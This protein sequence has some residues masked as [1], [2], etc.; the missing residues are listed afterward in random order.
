MRAADWV[1]LAMACVLATV[2]AGAEAG[3]SGSASLEFGRF[4]TVAI[5]GATSNPSRVVLFVSGDGGWNQGVVDM[6]RELAKLDALVVGLD[7][8]RYLKQL[9][10][11]ETK[12]VYPAADF[13]ALS[14]FVQKKMGVPQYLHP[15][16][17][18]YSSGAT[19]VYATLVQSPPGTFR[20]AISLGFCPDLLL[21]K[22]MCPG[23][24]LTFHAGPK[25]KGV[26]FDPAKTLEDPWVALQGDIDKVCDPES[27]RAYVAKV[28]RGKLVW[29]P[30]VGHGYSVPSHWLPQLKDAYLEVVRPAAAPPLQA[31]APP[32]ADVPAGEAPGRSANEP[33]AA[34]PEAPG[35]ADLPLV[36]VP[37]KGES[38]NRFAVIVSGDGGWT[39]LD[40]HVGDVLAQAGIAV[41]GFDSLHYFWT[42]RTPDG[43]AADLA[44]ILRHYLAAWKKDHVVLVGYSRGADVL[45]FMVRRLPPELLEHVDLLALLGPSLTVGF[46]IHVSDFLGGK[47]RDD[48]PI[49]P[50]A[51]QLRVRKILCV[52]GESETETLCPSLPEPLSKPVKLKG[53][54]HFD[55]AYEEI[56]KLILDELPRP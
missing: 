48:L 36:E 1:A 51:T 5:Y 22:P 54:H 31:Q 32:A 10:S 23:S 14:Q 41:V 35:V 18:G 29:L 42:R 17:V 46:E 38:Q 37:A 26:L 15:V 11:A 12:C 27:T 24:G 39:S 4:G 47:H 21:R 52:Y 40:R 6:A 55:G 45:P 43:A 33:G 49:L 8:R 13:E 19:L 9:E 7:I 28:P 2:A 44:R 20:A 53:A 56:G 50:E 16:L 30:K 34:E 3:A 25:G